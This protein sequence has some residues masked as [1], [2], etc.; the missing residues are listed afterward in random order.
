MRVCTRIVGLIACVLCELTFTQSCNSSG[1]LQGEVFIV[2]RGGENIKLGLVEVKALPLNK[3]EQAVSRLLAIREKKQHLIDEIAEAK[4][5]QLYS[6]LENQLKPEFERVAVQEQNSWEQLFHEQP[7]P[8]ASDKTG[9]D[10]KFSFQLDRNATV[11]LVAQATR[12]LLDG[13]EETYRWVVR[14]SLDGQ[15]TKRIFL[16]NDNLITSGSQD[17]LLHVVE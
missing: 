14:A 12:K 11:A 17:S 15:A 8:S 13:T 10:G 4:S 7:L 3:A 5:F 2:T 1:T 9:A 6:K 16:S